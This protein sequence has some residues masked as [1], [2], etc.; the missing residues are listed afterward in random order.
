[1]GLIKAYAVGYEEWKCNVIAG[2]L[3]QHPEALEQKN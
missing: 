1:M 2:L 3:K